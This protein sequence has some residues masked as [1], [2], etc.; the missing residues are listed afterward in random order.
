VAQQTWRR[1]ASYVPIE[2]LRAL[3]RSSE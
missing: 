3:E 2:V 1:N